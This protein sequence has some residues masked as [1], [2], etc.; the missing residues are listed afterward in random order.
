LASVVIADDGVNF[1][2]VDV[3][4][5]A[6]VDVDTADECDDKQHVVVVEFVA[7]ASVAVVFVAAA[8]VAVVAAEFVAVVAAEFVDVVAAAFVDVAFVDVVFVAVAADNVDYAEGA[9]A[10][11]NTAAGTQKDPTHT[12]SSRP[13]LR[14]Q[15]PRIRRLEAREGQRPRPAS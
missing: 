3:G 7:V 6:I 13:F 1:I 11:R 2:I 12:P 5:I 15:I 14:N 4:A 9:D 8:F 10:G